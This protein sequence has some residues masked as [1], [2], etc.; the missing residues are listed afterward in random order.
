MVV[1]SRFE[2]TVDA[3]LLIAGGAAF[4]FHIVVVGFQWT[5]L[6]FDFRAY[7][8][9]AV[10]ADAGL[11]P[12]SEDDILVW[13]EM[14]GLEP[15]ALPFAYQPISLELF[16]PLGLM[17]FHTA[18]MVWIGVQSVAIATVFSVLWK[19]VGLP[20]GHT[21][22]VLAF[23]FNAAAPLVL[24]HG[25]ITLVCAALFLVGLTLAA[26]RPLAAAVLSV[27][28][29]TPKPWIG[30]VVGYVLVPFSVR[31]VIVLAVAVAVGIGLFAA[32]R[33]LYPQEFEQFVAGA[34]AMILLD[35]EPPGPFKASVLDL[36]SNIEGSLGL[37]QG[38][39][40]GFY[41]P[42][43]MIVALVTLSGMWRLSSSSAFDLKTRTI[44]SFALVA[45]AVSLISPRLLLY[46][47]AFALPAAA[48][49]LNLLRHLAARLAGLA[50]VVF[51][52]VHISQYGFDRSSG[53]AV[54]DFTH[55]FW[56]YWTI[57]A[58][59]FCYALLLAH[60]FRSQPVGAT[61]RAI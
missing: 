22:A 5:E 1:I 19:Y 35:T 13:S 8:F 15:K 3:A 29:A 10:A 46:Q 25:Q 59:L 57:F 2:K 49:A 34:E 28:A 53:A 36:F 11:D 16:R 60:V 9:A 51:P 48:I 45:L 12:Y 38:A 7:Y 26:R 56:F 27:L 41:V 14:M 23:G 43:V 6:Q 40:I 30:P 4:L 37:T 18:Y 58:A 52:T 17:D 32:S 31:R 54:T 42:W 39:R 44:L 55:V 33:Y 50:V 21:L 47:W 61:I 20:P 24:R